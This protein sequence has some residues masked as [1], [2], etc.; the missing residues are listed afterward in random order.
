M[1]THAVNPTRLER[2]NQIAREKIAIRGHKLLKDKHDEIF[3][4]VR[5]LRDETRELG[6]RV[7]TDISHAVKLFLRSRAFMTATEI[8]NAIAT[9]KTELS[10]TIETKN[11]YGL[12]VPELEIANDHPAPDSPFFHTTHQ[13]FD[14]SVNVLESVMPKLVRLATLEKTVKMLDNEINRLQRRINA[15]EYS[16]IPE[17]HKNITTISMK[18]AENERGNL[19]RLMKVK[20]MQKE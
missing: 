10:L 11:I 18:L 12:R 3:R 17:I 7:R 5:T 14:S 8:D 20:Q 13:S 19:V 6:E 1:S 4:T 16:V 9:I 2:N 15:L